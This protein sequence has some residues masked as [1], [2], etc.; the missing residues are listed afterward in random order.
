M[1]NLTRATY[2][3][4]AYDAF[5]KTSPKYNDEAEYDDRATWS[6]PQWRVFIIHVSSRAFGDALQKT[7]VFGNTPLLLRRRG[8][9]GRCAEEEKR[10]ESC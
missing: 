9:E 1:G 4:S 3:K 6:N 5:C 10:I 8:G 2:A 7:W